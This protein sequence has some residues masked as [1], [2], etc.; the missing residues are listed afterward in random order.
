MYEQFLRLLVFVLDKFN[1]VLSLP[2]WFTESRFRDS[3]L[4]GFVSA[5]QTIISKITFRNRLLNFHFPV[6]AIEHPGALTTDLAFISILEG[7]TSLD[8]TL[9]RSAGD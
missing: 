5:V 7:P 1:S 9:L 4:S 6:C 2:D 8:L 3:T